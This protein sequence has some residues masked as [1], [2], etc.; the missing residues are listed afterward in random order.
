[1][2][3]LFLDNPQR[4]TRI[5]RDTVSDIDYACAIE[6]VERSYTPLWWAALVVLS[7]VAC[8]VIVVTG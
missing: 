7:C 2:K 5:R 4:Y 8:F 3:P 1:M 6:H